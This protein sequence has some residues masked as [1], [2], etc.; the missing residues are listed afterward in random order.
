MNITSNELRKL[1]RRT[2]STDAYID[3]IFNA[4]SKVLAIRVDLYYNLNHPANAYLTE[5]IAKSHINTYLNN[6]RSFQNLGELVAGHLIRLERADQR[7]FHFH[8]LFLLDGQRVNNGFYYAQIL[9][10]YWIRTLSSA[11]G[12]N[13]FI[14][15]EGEM[16]GSF[17]I[18]D[19]NDYVNSG[20]GMI[21]YYDAEKIQCLKE[22]VASYLLKPHSNVNSGFWKGQIKHVNTATGRPRMYL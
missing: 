6:F 18:C 21:D 9:G 12:R 8:C 15:S 20:I 14:L 17:N 5:D 13:G 4:Y 10:N 2:E 1:N 22:R 3:S 11:V 16:L 7:G 19:P